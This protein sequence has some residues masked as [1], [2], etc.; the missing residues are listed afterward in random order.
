[1]GKEE[2]KM[3]LLIHS[4]AWADPLTSLGVCLLLRVKG[5][6]VGCLG[7]YH[8]T[9]VLNN[10]RSATH[11]GDVL[12]VLLNKHSVKSALCSCVT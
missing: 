6:F 2:Q 10:S 11:R 4:C 8:G 9:S 3:N 1:M 7:N 5:E 12:G